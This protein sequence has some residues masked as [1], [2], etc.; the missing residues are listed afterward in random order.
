[1]RQDGDSGNRMQDARRRSPYGDAMAEPRGSPRYA[2]TAALVALLALAGCA[3]APPARNARPPLTPQQ[4]EQRQRLAAAE[5]QCRQ[6]AADPQLAP[7]KGRL[8]PHDQG[9]QWTREMMIDQKRVTEADRALLVLMDEKRAA[10]RQ[11]LLNASPAQTVPLLDYYQRQDQALVRVYNRQG[12]IGD[13]N[14]AMADAQAQLS[15]DL[16]NLQAETAARANR[17]AIDPSAAAPRGDTGEVSLD[18]L[19]ALRPR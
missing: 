13:Y 10:C 8:M 7:L 14:R 12:T 11:A 6:I 19:R 4:I 1:M 18:R 15:I 9:Q 17:E 3:S 5:A 16:T 2:R